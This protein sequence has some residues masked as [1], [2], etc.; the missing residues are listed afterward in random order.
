MSTFGTLAAQR[1]LARN[2]LE[3][4]EPTPLLVARLNARRAGIRAEIVTVAVIMAGM[5]T[6]SFIDHRTR[7]HVGPDR[8]DMRDFVWQITFNV[9]LVLGMATGFWWRYR[10]ERVLLAGMTVRSA[11]P[12]AVG[13]ARMLGRRRLVAAV[14][15]NVGGIAVS[16]GVALLAPGEPD[17]TL[18]TTVAVGIAVLAALGALNLAAVLRRPSLAE[19]S[20]SL[21]VDDVLRT[22]DARRAIVPYA[23]LVGFIAAGASTVG[24]W[25]NWPFLAYTV[26][27]AACWWLGERCPDRVAVAR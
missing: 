8:V 6:W 26:A 23:L 10:T 5:L 13:P 7:G 27:G 19:D 4:I 17:R 25:V 14:A 1:W 15:V 20:A 16:A 22:D 2:R 9:A 21:D 11:H 18:A 3:H 12:S 24:S